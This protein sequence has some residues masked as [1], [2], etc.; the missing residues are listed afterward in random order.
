MKPDYK[1]G[2]LLL[3]QDAV[4][5]TDDCRRMREVLLLERPTADEVLAFLDGYNAFI[6]H[7]SRPFLPM[8]ETKMLL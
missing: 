5:L 8:R 7:A 4:S 1:K 3:G 2:V 6:N